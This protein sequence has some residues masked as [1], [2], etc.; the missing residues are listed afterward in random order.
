M[1]KIFKT[2][3]SNDNELDIEDYL[4]SI[5]GDIYD[6]KN[7]EIITPYVLNTNGKDYYRVNL[8]KKEGGKKN[9]KIH[10][11]LMLS[12]VGVHENED[13]NIIDHIDGNGLNNDLNNLRWVTQK[14]N[15]NNR[16][17]NKARFLQN[18]KSYRIITREFGKDKSNT[19][20][21]EYQID[22][23]NKLFDK[24]Q[25]DNKNFFR[26]EENKNSEEYKN[27]LNEVNDIKNNTFIF[28]LNKINYL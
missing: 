2:L 18:K 12:F 24:I 26:D 16:T 3:Y 4:I 5:N 28:T 27:Y 20:P 10:R 9:C 13:R 25:E 1:S 6:C 19:Y 11:L 22:R 15:N 17:P 8:R 21:T 23:H 7:E 14:E